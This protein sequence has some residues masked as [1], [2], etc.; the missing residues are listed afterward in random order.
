MKNFKKL[1]K[2]PFFNIILILT[3]TFLALYFSLKDNWQDVLNILLNSNKQLI[4]VVFILSI[5]Y[6]FLNGLILTIFAK[7]YN[8]SYSVGK[9]FINSLIAAFFHGITPSAT[10]GQFAQVY[11]FRKQGVKLSNAL[12]ILLIDFILFQ[13]VLV[14]LALTFILIGY[15]RFQDLFSDM[16]WLVVLGFIV[17]CAVITVLILLA[18][19]TRFYRFVTKFCFQIGEKLH[20]IKNKENNVKRIDESVSNFKAA[21]KLLK[22]N[23]KIMIINIILNFARLLLTFSIPAVACIAVG[24]KVDISMFFNMIIIACF[25]T[26]INH[27]VPIPGASGTMEAT[28]L[29]LF[30]RFI[31]YTQAA[32]AV[33][34][35]RFAT[36]HFI[37][38]TAGIVFSIFRKVNEEGE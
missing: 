38:F 19:S 7:I 23:N 26:L 29:L 12:S 36:F 33:I 27:M 16:M 2:N 18:S 15:S 25:V 34:I 30:S 21:I 17:D 28:F 22:E 3:I 8:P 4:G 5:G 32:S 6:I 35:W 20:I 24:A 13:S 37:L 14:I 31:P 1:L 9:G 11:V 10:G